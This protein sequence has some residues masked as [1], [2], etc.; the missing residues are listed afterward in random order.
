V[1]QNKYV[2]KGSNSVL[3]QL[4]IGAGV[5]ILMT[6]ITVA[7]GAMLASKEMLAEKDMGYIAMAI[8]L[9][10]S[11]AGAKAGTLKRKEKVAYISLMIGMI[12]ALVLLSVTALFFE[13]QFHAVSVS[14]IV[15]LSGCILSVLFGGKRGKGIKTRRSKKA[16]R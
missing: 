16:Y 4:L 2:V 10:S 5:C 1:T 14:V 3:G 9:C 13:G 8:L 12:Y 11:I 6:L 15:I 7:V